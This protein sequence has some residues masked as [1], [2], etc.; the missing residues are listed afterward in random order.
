MSHPMEKPNREIEQLQARARNLRH[1]LSHQL[2]QSRKKHRNLLVVGILLV[3]VSM[4][5]LGNVT[6]LTFALDAETL[7]EIGRAEV[8]RNLPASRQSL[9]SYLESEAPR[10]A[11][12]VVSGIS[13][14]IPSLRP[15]L[16]EQITDHTQ[17]L[18]AELE[19]RLISEMRATIAA[20]RAQIDQEMP[21]AGDVEKVGRLVDVVAA[22][23]QENAENAFDALY[24][25]YSAEMERV[26]AFLERLRTTPESELTAKER[27]Q[28]EIIQTILRLAIH[29]HE[30]QKDG[31]YD[32]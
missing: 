2:E 23:F 32:L 24:P 6:R 3:V 8:E 18:T 16:L 29:A 11:E 26:L 13:S 17:A 20:S 27:I 10:I 14:S 21:S 25:E 5:A 31:G 22:R 12:A 1:V 7:T 9:Q 30:I 19:Q 15:L 28:K 4:A